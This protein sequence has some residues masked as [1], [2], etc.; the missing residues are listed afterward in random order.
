MTGSCNGCGDCCAVVVLNREWPKAKARA[1]VGVAREQV[2]WYGDPAWRDRL[3][4]LAW[5]VSLRRL[6]AAEA[7]RR[8]P[9]LK[10]RTRGL[11]LWE[12]P[13]FDYSSRRCRDYGNRPPVCRNFP[14]YGRD[15]DDP[16]AVSLLGLPR[17]GYR[18]DRIEVLRDWAPAHG[19]PR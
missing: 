12:C 19:T 6:S 1:E 5:R 17:C 11:G 7:V 10:G 4:D 8:S 2:K 9:A 15:P 14:W 18:I 13:N 3:A 16:G